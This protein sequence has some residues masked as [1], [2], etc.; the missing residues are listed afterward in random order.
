MQGVQGVEDFGFL[1]LGSGLS[2]FRVQVWWCLHK[3]S[4]DVSDEMHARDPSALWGLPIKHVTASA[5]CGGGCTNSKQPVDQQFVT[6]NWVERQPGGRYV[7]IAGQV[8]LIT[9]NEVLSIG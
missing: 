4:S 3:L 9:P 1:G 7:R 6:G 8:I 5:A 2:F